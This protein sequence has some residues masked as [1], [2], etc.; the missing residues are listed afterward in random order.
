M[1]PETNTLPKQ[2]PRGS[3]ARLLFQT[4]AG[5]S[6]NC[7]VEQKNGDVVRKTAGCA[8]FEGEEVCAALAS[9][10]RVLCPLLTYFYPSKKLTAKERLPNG[11]I[12]KI[13]EKELKTPF[14]RL[15]EDPEIAKVYQKRAIQ[16]KAALD[17]VSLQDSLESAC[18]EL[19]YL[20]IKNHG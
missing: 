1:Y 16:T 9:V 11:R 7:F 17:I 13:Y 18:Q 12:K 10:Y 6:A 15:C 14:Q 19:D 3:A 2:Q 5:S 20:V 8:R 4:A